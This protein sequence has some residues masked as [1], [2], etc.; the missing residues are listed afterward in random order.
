MGTKVIAQRV[1]KLREA[2]GWKRKELARYAKC[3]PKI[4]ERME[5]EGYP[6]GFR[7]ENITN[8]ATALSVAPGVLTGE[9]PMPSDPVD[10]RAPPGESSVTIRLQHHVR[11]AA[12]LIALRYGVRA[13]LPFE[14]APLLFVLHAEQ[15]QAKRKARLAEI[16]DAYASRCSLLNHFRHLPVHAVFDPV[17]EEAYEAETASIERRDLFGSGIE[18]HGSL[19]DEAWHDDY[20]ED[21]HNPFAATLRELAVD[22]GAPASVEEI[23]RI[24]P[25][26]RLCRDEALA[27]AGGE[28]ELADAIQDGSVALYEL[29]AELRSGAPSIARLDWLRQKLSQ[30]RQE[31]DAFLREIGILDDA[32]VESSPVPGGSQ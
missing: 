4:I 1:G 8:V 2:K 24:R 26:Y 30:R 7:L 9:L 28:E 5:A 11:N 32:A 25:Q 18:D 23:G 22:L 6:G 29:P 15:S 16:R 21:A 17:A 20:D 3:S 13:A 31:A 19:R 14:L 12:A 27:F 10:R